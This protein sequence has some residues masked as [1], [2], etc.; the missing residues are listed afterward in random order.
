MRNREV[1]SKE[2]LVLWIG[3]SWG[4][5]GIKAG[6]LVSCGRPRTPTPRWRQKEEGTQASW[7]WEMVKPREDIHRASES[8][9]WKRRQHSGAVIHTAIGKDSQDGSW[10]VR[11]SEKERGDRE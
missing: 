4:G 8:T 5:V 10:R 6:I 7:V 2:D 11:Q 3:S 9:A 1:L